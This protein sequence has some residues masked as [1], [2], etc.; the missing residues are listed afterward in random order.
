MATP[1]TVK[2]E[3]IK[4]LIQ[5]LGAEDIVELIAMPKL[6]E[7]AESGEFNTEKVKEYISES[8]EKFNLE[9][10]SYL[11]LGCTHFPYFKTTLKEKEKYFMQLFDENIVEEKIEINGL[12]NVDKKDLKLNKKI[13][14]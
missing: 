2:G 6:V 10:Y 3:K 12:E 14:C 8:L 11:V 5:R 9:E 13:L 7:F 1:V 4:N